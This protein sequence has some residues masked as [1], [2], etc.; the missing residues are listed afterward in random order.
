MENNK[1]LFRRLSEY[2]KNN[3]K[4]SF[5]DK[6]NTLTVT[7]E[8]KVYQ[9]DEFVRDT[10]SSLAFT[11][12]ELMIKSM[13]YYLTWHVKSVQLFNDLFINTFV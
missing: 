9:F 4:L 8:D 11:S 6:F 5:V 2:F 3:I 13:I 1:K 12:D 10:Y 7:K